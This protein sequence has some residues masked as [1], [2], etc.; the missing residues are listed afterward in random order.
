MEKPYKSIVR[1][2]YA[3]LCAQKH[4]HLH[5]LYYNT[6]VTEIISISPRI[7]RFF[8]RFPHDVHYKS[9]QFVIID[10]GKLPH[11][12][13]TR[14]YS[15][16]DV[17]NGPV[18]ELC[19]SLKEDGAATPILFHQKIGD[20]LRVSEP[21]GRFVLP[22]TIEHKSI[23]FICT[24][25]GVA[26]FR[27]MIKDL[28]LFRNFRN[29]VHLYFGCRTQAEILYREE[30]E[31][32]QSEHPNFIY[33]PVLSRENWEGAEGY[34]HAHYEKAFSEKP[35]ALFYLCGWKDMLKETRENLKSYGYTRSEIR[36]EFYD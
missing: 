4:P 35:D 7:K 3:S 25:T 16:A 17:C 18:I 34:V 26:P 23:A 33:T 14:S 2:F 6:E 28:L 10:F 20:V 13:A 30:F 15:I 11:P 9:G 31:A 21:Q 24:G 19:V 36:I 12:Y 8:I 1:F 32:L 27:A 5:T 22:E 29:P